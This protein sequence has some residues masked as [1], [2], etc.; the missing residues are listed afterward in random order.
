ACYYAYLDSLAQRWTEPVK[1]YFDDPEEERRTVLYRDFALVMLCQRIEDLDEWAKGRLACV[2]PAAVEEKQA[3]L[4]EAKKQLQV[5]MG[6][7]L[8]VIDEPYREKITAAHRSFYTFF[9]SNEKFVKL[10]SRGAPA[11]VV[12]EDL[13]QV[14]RMS[15]LTS[16][17][18]YGCRFFRREREE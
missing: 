1:I 16:D 18:Y 15:S 17:Y 2:E 7:C 13:L 10:L 8:Y 12:A 6:L 3:E 9:D 14:Q 4:I 5:D 11:A